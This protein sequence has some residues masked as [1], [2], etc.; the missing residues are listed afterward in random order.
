MHVFESI[1]GLGLGEVDP[2][3]EHF[4]DSRMIGEFTVDVEGHAIELNQGDDLAL[5]TH[6][7]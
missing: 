3:L 1:R 5:M 2:A 6:R 4:G 7:R